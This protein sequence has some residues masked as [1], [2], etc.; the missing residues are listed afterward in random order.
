MSE[1]RWN[2]T[3][4]PPQ[5]PEDNA[6]SLKRDF[7]KTPTTTHIMQNR[8]K[9]QKI[10]KISIF[11]IKVYI[12]KLKVNLNYSKSLKKIILNLSQSIRCFENKSNFF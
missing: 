1:L 4:Q 2:T 3:T 8:C 6:K 9:L 7:L 5:S 10:L 11:F 12:L